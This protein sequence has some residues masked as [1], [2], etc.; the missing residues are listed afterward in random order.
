MFCFFFLI[1]RDWASRWKNT[2]D[3]WKTPLDHRRRERLI[4]LLSSSFLEQWFGF[5]L[6]LFFFLPS[7]LS[8]SSVGLLL[9]KLKGSVFP[10]GGRSTEIVGKVKWV[11]QLV[12]VFGK[13]RRPV[14]L[15]LLMKVW[16][17][18]MEKWWW[19]LWVLGRQLEAGVGTDLRR[20]LLGLIWV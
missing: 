8:L 1:N 2:W 6:P 18:E 20:L 5:Y 16:C 3:H 7:V 11:G 10:V 13:K 17:C 9:W 12:C 15:C 14:V 4:K 19:W